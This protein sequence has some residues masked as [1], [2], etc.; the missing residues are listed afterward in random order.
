MDNQPK[1]ALQIGLYRSCEYIYLLGEKYWHNWR[2]PVRLDEFESET[3][4]H[5]YGVDMNKESIAHCQKMFP[6]S[7]DD[8]IHFIEALIHKTKNEQLRHDNF[9]VQPGGEI[10]QT[11]ITLDDLFAKIPIPV[12]L[13]CLDVERA[14]LPILQGFQWTQHPAYIII[15][16]H[17]INDL[18]PIAKLLKAENYRFAVIN[19]HHL[20]GQIQ[21]AF[22]H[23]T[24]R[25][26]RNYLKVK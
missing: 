17:L 12:R 13:L 11:A 23:K 6:E 26:D 24:V 10:I 9:V 8:R 20:H 2:I 4:W 19:Q 14:E 7:E 5:Y 25:T 1:A 22:I 21:C 15:E 16:V 18:Y 3:G